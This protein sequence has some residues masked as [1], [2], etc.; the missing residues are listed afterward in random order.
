MPIK[1]ITVFGGTGFLGRRIVACLLARGF[2]V[3]V[4][5]RRPDRVKNIKGSTGRLEPFRADVRD[6]ASVSAA[7]ENAEAVVNA[8]SLYI[9]RGEATFRAIHVDGAKRVAAAAR[10]QSARLVHISGIGADPKSPS[11]YVRSRGEGELGVREEFGQATIFR[12][13]VMFGPDDAFVTTLTSLLRVLP[14]LPVFGKGRTRMQPVFVGDVADALANALERPDTEG[15]TYEL[16][17]PTIYTYRDLVDV[18]MRHAGRR[19]VL[20]PVPYFIWNVL[21]TAVSI[22][23]EPPLTEGQVALMKH[24]NIASPDIPGLQDLDI[25]PTCFSEVLEHST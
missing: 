16:G 11:P 4:A 21:A 9:E 14:A 22:L 20:I 19:R 15:G 7:T 3:R 17:G 10:E 1:R 5:A 24:D 2:V 25:T 6:A 18:V 13:S 23:S 8:V 12:P